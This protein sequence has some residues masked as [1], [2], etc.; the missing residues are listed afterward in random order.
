MPLR[1]TCIQIAIAAG[2]VEIIPQN[3][4]NNI[5]NPRIIKEAA[6]VFALIGKREYNSALLAVMRLA[7]MPAAMAGPD[8]FEGFYNPVNTIGQQSGKIQI[9]KG[10]EEVELLLGET[11]LGHD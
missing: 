5:V 2:I 7:V 10:V 6:Q 3:A 8:R 1:V 4:R 11:G 9:A